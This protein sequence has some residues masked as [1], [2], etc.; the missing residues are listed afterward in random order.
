MK[1]NTNKIKIENLI[2]MAHDD[3]D[4]SIANILAEYYESHCDC[5]NE[6]AD[7]ETGWKPWAME[8]TD[9][10]LDR[11]A[12]EISVNPTVETIF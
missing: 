8:K 3:E 7:P 1:S 6:A 4:V 2:A 12:R 11:V 5:P 10:L 9:E